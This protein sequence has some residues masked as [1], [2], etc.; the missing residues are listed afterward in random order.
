MEGRARSERVYD[1]ARAPC[2]SRR[3]SVKPLERR[4]GES[5]QTD[6]QTDRGTH[7]QSRG[8]PNWSSGAQRP[9][10]IAGGIRTPLSWKS[11]TYGCE[12]PCLPPSHLLASAL[13]HREVHAR[14]PRPRDRRNQ[15]AAHR[16]HLPPVVEECRLEAAAARGADREVARHDGD[17]VQ[18]VGARHLRQ[19]PRPHA[20]SSALRL[21]E[22]ARGG[23]NEREHRDPQHA[24]DVQRVEYGVVVGKGRAP[25]AVCRGRSAAASGL[26][27]ATVRLPLQNEQV[28]AAVDKQEA[29]EDAHHR[30]ANRRH[31]SAGETQDRQREHVR[32]DAADDLPAPSS[33]AEEGGARQERDCPAAEDELE[34]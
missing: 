12:L 32:N 24:V 22:A 27:L 8:R 9:Q 15:Q 18:R 28:K 29:E 23:E 4:A 21:L 11:P 6:R 25:A 2:L 31:R 14:R 10:R 5:M 19:Q 26:A 20:P 13:R 33:D 34:H 30:A 3:G 16:E 17:N 7:G 1:Q